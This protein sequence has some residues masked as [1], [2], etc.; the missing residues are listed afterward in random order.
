[1]S[2][3]YSRVRFDPFADFS[4]VDMQQGRVQLDSDWN[5]W[6]AILDRRRR[7]E[8][9][10]TFGVHPKP[11]I[12][13]V[14]VVSP[15]TPDAFKIVAAN[16]NISIG[17]GRMYVDGLLAEN[18][19]G[20]DREFDPVLAESR[21]K[22]PLAYE[23]QPYFPNPPVL[24]ADGKYLAYLEVWPREVTYLQRP[25][26]VE[27]AVGV[28]TTT[29]NQTVW[30]VRMLG[31]I[32]DATCTT[33]EDQIPAWQALI[34]PSDGRMSIK[35]ADV[36][37]D[38]DPCQMPP[39]GGYRGLEN[40]L[41]RIEI[42]D[43]GGQ[44]EATFKW[45]RDNASVESDVVQIVLHSKKETIL[46]LSSLGR[47]NVL[48]FDQGDWVEILDDW[49]ELGGENADPTKRRG[50]MR[51]ITSVSESDQ[52]ITFSTNDPAGD[53]D[54]PADMIPGG[55]ADTPATRHTRVKRWDQK[56]TVRDS[57]GNAVIDLDSQGA[58]GLIPVPAAGTWVLL[59]KGIQVQFGLASP[60]GKYHCGDYW[61]SAARTADASVEAFTQ[62]PPRGIHRHYTRLSILSFPL[63]PKV[64][65]PDCR[66][67]WPPECGTGGCCTVTVSPGDP[68]GSIAAAIHSLPTVTGGCVCLKAG[69]HDIDATIMITSG[70]ITLRGEG[71]G[72]IIRSK[73]VGTILQIGDGESLVN[74]VVIESIRFEAQAASGDIILLDQCSQVRIERCEV[75]GAGMTTQAIG[76]HLQ[77]EADN[78]DISLISNRLEQVPFGIVVSDFLGE[79]LIA[80]NTID[81]GA[82][83][84][85]GD[86]GITIL[87]NAQI[88]LQLMAVNRS[89]VLAIG[90]KYCRIEHNRISKFQ[91]G[92][93][94]Y[95]V[96]APVVRGNIVESQAGLTAN[97][98]GITANA[99]SISF[100]VWLYQCIN[101]C[102]EDNGLHDSKIGVVLNGGA[103]NRIRNNT[104]DQADI[105]IA[106]G[107]ESGP[108]MA[109]NTLQS[110]ELF[111]MALL[112]MHGV[113]ISHN[114][115]LNCGFAA[116]GG[117]G[118]I[119]ISDDAISTSES[120]ETVQI[121]SCEI[122]D[123]GIGITIDGP[124]I[125]NG[126][127]IGIA[128]WVSSC[129][130]VDNRVGYSQQGLQQGLDV[131]KEHRALLLLGPP[132]AIRIKPS[133]NIPEYQPI[134]GSALVSANDF[135]GPGK[136]ALI[137][138]PSFPQFGFEKVTFSNNICRH[139]KAVP[140]PDSNAVA[141]VHLY[142]GNLVALGNHIK[143]DGSAENSLSL[144]C[145][146]ASVMGNVTSGNIDISNVSVG[147]KPPIDANNIV[148]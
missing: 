83:E 75:V 111:G 86:A 28:D 114:R 124:V 61:V 18:H 36:P 139:L 56:G 79:L 117:A 60:D 51:K 87:P 135:R 78:S 62:A 138:F 126:I 6:A 3:D 53:V 130:I 67:H 22:N 55:G 85:P 76:I 101:G 34:R 64:D 15:Q 39:G 107:N 74:D 99:P 93:V 84:S 112:G 59:E 45:S 24:P 72:T 33:P 25:G 88:S 21:G 42:H 92:I 44:G 141:T 110:C 118:I 23:K 146:Q 73:K 11:G 41:Y 89:A 1:M 46:K 143:A 129:E 113:S 43:G 109:G 128:G 66:I 70:N 29:R 119:V 47:D 108:V 106:A 12:S 77:A 137:G 136:S 90:G 121:E 120:G 49:R 14:A 35:T 145:T 68:A 127:A 9:V 122:V 98:P 4:G 27:N 115:I 91:L 103:L 19:G 54:L 80:S 2:G 95:Q 30:Q 31:N 38:S 65:S 132:A 37:A 100:G 57:A 104:I 116:A 148:A 142:G 40:Q 123:T 131:Q 7:A 140:K 69:V 125:T 105:G 96:V 10:D 48:R 147:C 81:A 5:E 102:I 82:S 8:S 13:G 20:G 32:G 16:G 144:G 71:P 52:T 94:I 97:A 17:R 50:V 63:D 26:L 134:Q 58:S 133:A